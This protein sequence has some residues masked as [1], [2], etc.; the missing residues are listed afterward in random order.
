MN[1]RAAAGIFAEQY[2]QLRKK[3][4]R[5]YT[6]EELLHLPKLSKTH[7]HYKEWLSRKDSCRRLIR[8]LS[9]KQQP[10]HILEVGCGNGWLSAQLAG[11]KNAVVTGTDINKEELEQARRVFAGKS[12]LSFTM[13]EPGKDI[14][15]GQHYDVIVFAA[16]MQYFPSVKKTAAAAVSHLTLMGEVHIL[17]TAFYNRKQV[18][19]AG[20]RSREYFTGLSFPQMAEY[21]FHHCIDTMHHFEHRLLYN[22]GS[23][24]NRLK[25]VSNPF[26]HFVITGIK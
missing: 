9:K 11:I 13:G 19:A 14:L 23:F 7:P 2:S 21:Y 24:F 15:P 20:V 5:F 4:N 16:S 12:N 8:Y 1:S 22:P 6:D 26:H 3:E 18:L 17:D 10:L 25:P